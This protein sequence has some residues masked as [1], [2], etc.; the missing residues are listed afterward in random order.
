ME[1]RHSTGRRRSVA[2]QLFE[3]Y[4]GSQ[5]LGWDY[6]PELG[7][8]HPDYLVRYPGGTFAIEVEELQAPD[9]LPTTGYDP[10]TAIRDALRRA[11]N[12]LRGCKHMPTGIVLYSEAA[13]R[14]VTP[15]TVASAALGPG[16]QDARRYDQVETRSPALR[17]PGKY[18]CPVDAPKLAN[19]FLSRTANRTVS[20]VMVLMRYRLSDFDLAL[21]REL[22]DRQAR[23]EVLR[24]GASLDVAAQ[25]QHVPRTYQWEFSF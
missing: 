25:L 9:A 18:E 21:W 6:E 24:P 19:P 5:G 8:R 22:L 12:Q 13:H 7:G 10:A 14:S 23:G 1:Q 15:V 3:S 17:F 20:A 11:R 16:Y 2:E 4:L